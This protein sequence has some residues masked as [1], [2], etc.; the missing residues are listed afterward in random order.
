MSDDVIIKVSNEPHLGNANSE[1]R[2]Q[3]PMCTGL[4]DY[5][6]DALAYVA[7]VS[8]RGNNK[9]NPGQPTHWAREKSADHADAAIRHLAR[10]GLFD[11]DGLRE[12]GCAVWRTLC[13]LQEELEKAYE[14]PPSRG[15]RVPITDEK[16]GA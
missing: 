13:V 5:F 15:S 3:M 14:L 11:T 1:Q 4:L 7:Y 16:S 6:P 2:K 12:S 9:H 8:W 10:R